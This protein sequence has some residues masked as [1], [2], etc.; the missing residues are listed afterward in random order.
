MTEG[1]S[2]RNGYRFGNGT[3]RRDEPYTSQPAMTE[4]GVSIAPLGY[5]LIAGDGAFVAWFGCVL[6]A[7]DALKAHRGP[8]KVVR[9]SDRALLKARRR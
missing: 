5:E 8:G 1:R 7:V 6:D 4:P 2:H 3:F 9:C